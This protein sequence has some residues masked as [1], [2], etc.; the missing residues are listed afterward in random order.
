M[1]HRP[2]VALAAGAMLIVGACSSSA[3]TSAPAA[4]PSAAP[5]VEASAPP[6]AGAACVESA[7]AGEV[8]VAIKDFAFGPAD[9]Q[10][11]VGQTVTFT[12]GDSAPHTATLDDGSC[13]TPNIAG[14][15]SD[16]LMFS[17]AGS[18]P[19]HCN[20]HPNMKGTITVS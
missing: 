8:A 4:A 18:Y 5:S 6:A 7:A 12:N 1:R 19:F 13:T 16:G 15:G 17:A 10:A 3:A 14:G 2:L 11:K 20:V 9:I